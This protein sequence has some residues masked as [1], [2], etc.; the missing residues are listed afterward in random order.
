MRAYLQRRILTSLAVL[1]G[2]SILTFSI[3]H[4]V[5]GDP[6]AA[7]A[8][9]QAVSG[10]QA[11]ALRAQYGLDAPLPVQYL[12]YVGSAL[13]GDLGESIRTKQPVTT[14]IAAQLR[15]TVT[16]A[17]AAML[18]AVVV[19]LSLGTLAA[20][21]RNS[22]IDNLITLVTVSG[23][24]IPSFWLGMTLI[25]VFAVWLGWLPS[26]STAGDWR[27]MILPTI[28]LGVAEAAV[29]ARVTRA[30]MLDEY[31]RNYVQVARAK[32]LR[33]RLVVRGH[34]LPNVLIPVLTIIGLQVGFL[35]AGSIVVETVFARQ[36]IGRLAVSAINNRDYP[37]VQ[38]VTLF[39]SFAYVLINTCTDLA[40]AWLD[41][42]VR[43]S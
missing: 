25:L 30:A 28:T 27:G 11:E 23:I 12:R 10:A 36:G 24:S 31:D 43:L 20:M 37:L 41:P 15:S 39:I 4:L 3:L 19:G 18:F 17:A 38:G 6:V 21:R 26:S 9:R 5:P 14:M 33:E 34:L 32:G 40:Y 35:L 1:L 13:T 42:R 2:V 22:W 29:I 8:G 7:I 16:L